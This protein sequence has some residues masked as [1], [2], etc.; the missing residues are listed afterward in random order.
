MNW[1][2]GKWQLFPINFTAREIRSHPPSQQLHQPLGDNSFST[3]QLPPVYTN[4]FVSIVDV[5]ICIQSQNQLLMQF[6]FPFTFPALSYW[7]WQPG[8]TFTWLW[9]STGFTAGLTEAV[10]FYATPEFC[11]RASDV[12]FHFCRH[13]KDDELLHGH[14]HWQHGPLSFGSPWSDG[15]KGLGAIL[16]SLAVAFLFGCCVN[17]RPFTDTAWCWLLN[18]PEVPCSS[19]WHPEAECLLRAYLNLSSLQT[20]AGNR[21]VA[22]DFLCLS[23]EEDC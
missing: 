16:L 22:S 6:F 14:N 20:Q 17:G 4:G 18:H 9:E 2:G 3:V 23:S 13:L 7:D 11:S 8:A 21:I 5:Y 1:R 12:C 10:N 15:K 19:E